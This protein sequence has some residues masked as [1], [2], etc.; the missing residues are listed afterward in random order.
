MYALSFPRNIVPQ[1]FDSLFASWV[2]TVGDFFIGKFVTKLNLIRYLLNFHRP[3]F[4]G[5]CGI[6][7]LNT[8]LA[9]L[10]IDKSIENGIV[11]P[12]VCQ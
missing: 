12:T 1:D 6:N 5:F 4:G 3:V 10:S 9:K 8:F 7:K 2:A 11:L